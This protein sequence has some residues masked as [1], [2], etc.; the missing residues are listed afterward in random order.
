MQIEKYFFQ[1]LF[2]PLLQRRVNDHRR[3][4]E[5]FGFQ[6]HLSLFN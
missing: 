6:D 4:S 3:D 2:S 1:L 5:G